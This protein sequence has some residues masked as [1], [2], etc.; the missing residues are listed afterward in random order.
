MLYVIHNRKANKN[1]AVIEDTKDA[2]Q[3][4]G[5]M[6]DELPA[7]KIDEYVVILYTLTADEYAMK[8]QDGEDLLGDQEYIYT[9]PNFVKQVGLDSYVVSPAVEKGVSKDVLQHLSREE[10]QFVLL[11]TPYMEL[12]DEIVRRFDEYDNMSK[13]LYD[14]LDSLKIYDRG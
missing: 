2:L 1:Y 9:L 7:G 13:K 6:L 10:R 8:C 4:V 3:V 11:V 12:I 14:S 5:E